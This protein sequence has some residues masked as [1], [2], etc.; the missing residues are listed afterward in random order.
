MG[1]WDSLVPSWFLH[2]WYVDLEHHYIKQ[3]SIKLH[4]MPQDVRIL[5]TFSVRLKAGVTRRILT[6]Y[7]FS[8]TQWS[9]N[10]TSRF[11]FVMRQ[12]QAAPTAAGVEAWGERSLKA[13]NIPD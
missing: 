3:T 2:I 12:Q 6:A 10:L 5:H 1:Y 13:A 7:T 4:K 11:L 8:L 9:Q